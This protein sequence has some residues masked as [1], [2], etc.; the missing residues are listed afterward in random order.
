MQGISYNTYCLKKK[1]LL[2]AS[3]DLPSE[4]EVRISIV[5]QI[6]Y[7]EKLKLEMIRSNI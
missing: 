1:Q 6:I 5:A 2:M 3:Q 4:F 7:N